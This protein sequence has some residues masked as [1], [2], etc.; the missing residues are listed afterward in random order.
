MVGPY[1]NAAGTGT[2]A[3]NLN[4]SGIYDNSTTTR[5]EILFVRPSAFTYG[6][7]RQATLKSREVIETDQQVLVVLQRLTFANLY[8]GQTVVGGLYNILK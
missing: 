6:D 4:A 1:L 7:R 5:T 8:P 2:G 3:E